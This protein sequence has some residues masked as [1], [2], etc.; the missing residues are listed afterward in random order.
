MTHGAFIPQTSPLEQGHPGLSCSQEARIIPKEP[1]T[2]GALRLRGMCRP[3]AAGS[4][5]SGPVRGCVPLATALGR[6][7]APGST[8]PRSSAPPPSLHRTAPKEPCWDL[9]SFRQ[10]HP[11][12]PANA[13]TASKTLGGAE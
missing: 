12:L 9:E 2:Q 11:A 6:E 8:V 1:S 4:G 7:E 10:R 13:E 3:G 5:M